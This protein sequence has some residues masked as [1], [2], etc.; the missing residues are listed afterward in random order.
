MWTSVLLS[1]SR[2]K[3]INSAGSVGGMQINDRWRQAV[4][5]QKLSSLNQLMELSEENIHPMLLHLPEQWRSWAVLYHMHDHNLPTQ[6]L[7]PWYRFLCA[8]VV[9]QTRLQEG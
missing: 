9:P 3:K 5:F 1:N 2:L 7:Q 4:D 8:P 6:V